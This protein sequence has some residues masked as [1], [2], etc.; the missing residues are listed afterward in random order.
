MTAPKDTISR[1]F[2]QGRGGLKMRNKIM[3]YIVTIKIPMYVTKEVYVDDATSKTDARRKARWHLIGDC[4][5]YEESGDS[6]PEYLA[7]KTTILEI[8]EGK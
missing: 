4:D 7:H 8:K 3:D 5:M 1:L 2:P 6:D